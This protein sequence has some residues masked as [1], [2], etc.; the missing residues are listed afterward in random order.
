M[1]KGYHFF[2]VI[3]TASFFPLFFYLLYVI[4]QT[5][6][7]LIIPAVLT[8]GIAFAAVSLFRFFYDAPRPYEKDPSIPPPK[9]NAK[10]GQSFPSRHV[11]SAFTIASMI[12]VYRP[13]IGVIALVGA[14]FLAYLRVRCHFH[15]F[16]DV[17]CG[18]VLGVCT[19][20]IY[21][22]II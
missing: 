19:S 21:L 18:A 16:W 22:L 17:F 12:C 5:D 13:V 3:V 20:V 4:L 8:T 9:E 1:S 10:K 6:K 7:A 11:F 14:V 15:S 2:D